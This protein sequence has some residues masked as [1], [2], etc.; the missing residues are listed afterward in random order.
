MQAIQLYIE[1]ERV[2]MFKDESV[3]IIQTI[4]NVRD[5]SKVFTEFT[6]QFTVPASKTNNRIFQ[7]YYN[8]DINNGFDARVRKNANI[9][10]N[11]LPFKKGKVQLNGVDMRNNKPYAYRLTFTGNVVELKDVLG[12]DK[13]PSLTS[14]TYSPNVS[15]DIDKDYDAASVKSALTS[16]GSDGTL[17]PLITH[18]QRLYYDSSTS[19][20][21]SGNLYDG[22]V[23]QGLKF[24]ELK[25]AVKLSKIIDAIES[26]YELISFDS[27]S[28][29]KDATK[30]VAK[31]Y[32]WCHR[33]KGG[34][35]I[36]TGPVSVV[37]G[38]NPSENATSL[39]L[40][41]QS[42]TEG[43]LIDESTRT[44]DVL[45]FETTASANNFMYDIVIYRDTGSGYVHYQEQNRNFG[46]TVMTVLDPLVNG[47][48]YKAYIRTYESTSSF[49]S[50]SWKCS[51]SGASSGQDSFSV[52]NKNFVN[53]YSF[54][55][56]ENL[57]D[58]KIIDFLSGLFK[59]FNLV[60]YVQDDN[61]IQVK[62]LDDY[63]SIG[64]TPTEHDISKYIDTESSSIDVALP[65]KEIFFKYE[66]TDTILANQHLQEIADPPIEWGGVEY[67]DTNYDVS[68]DTYKVEPPFHHAKY[69]KILD[70]ANLN[71]STNVQVG[72]FVT[73]N[74]EAYLGKPLI[75]YVDQKQANVDIGFLDRNSK[76]S[77][78]TSSSINMPSNTEDIDDETS[79]NIHFG[80]EKSEFTNADATETLFSRFYQ[81][82]IESVFNSRNRLTRV[83]TI[84]PIG[85]IISIKL[86]DV[87]I[88]NDRKYRINSMETNLKDGRTSFELI[89]YYD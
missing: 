89:N 49:T 71:V 46:D 76:S 79:N 56:A 33:K 65:F 9:E 34:V 2:E 58:I 24:L 88:V 15:L 87:I 55:I 11:Y 13:L 27:N 50:M 23:V 60:A 30:D 36:P 1:D 6:R 84:L 54:N 21:Q 78:T 28:F 51:Y 80:V 86:S 57:P 44:A 40:K 42:D 12:E 32:M 8:Y 22:T 82:Y 20:Q 48:K 66:D 63:Y 4:R 47:Y 81:N 19:S 67:T 62:T 45:T 14:S 72:Y 70:A 38:F 74:E 26:K 3:N 83:K 31:L 37:G 17:I 68:G 53:S 7:H 61:T 16:V 41:V 29:F 64:G 69:E 52:S 75:M 77:I 35:E 18:S 10:L 59:M 85:K 43:V 25:Y 5:I 39:V 73:D